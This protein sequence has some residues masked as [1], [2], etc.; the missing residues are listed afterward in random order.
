MV[1]IRKEDIYVTPEEY[2]AGERLSDVRHEYLAGTV[3]AM[4]GGST[5]HARIAGNIFREFGNQLRGKPCEVFTSDM[6][7]RLRPAEGEFFYYPDVTVDCAPSRDPHAVY[8]EEPMVIVE[9]LSPSTERIDLSEKLGNYLRLPSLAVYVVV[10]QF[11]PHVT[12]HRRTAEGWAMEF[13]GDIADAIPFP[14]IGCMLPLTSI[15]E[16]MGF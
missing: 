2:L 3:H 1:A 11:S 7:V 14:E 8:L 4:S 16:R 13:Y 12:V 10:N 15:Y 5:A 9:V 6:K